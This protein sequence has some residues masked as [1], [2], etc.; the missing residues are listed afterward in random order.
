MSPTVQVDIVLVQ[1]LLSFWDSQGIDITP[2]W[3]LLGMAPAQPMPPWVNAEKLKLVHQY[4]ASQSSDRLLPAR[5]GRYLAQRDLP[6][7][8]LLK[9]SENLS[10]GLPAALRFMNSSLGSI[11]FVIR[12]AEHKVVVRAEP[13]P[14]MPLLPDQLLQALVALTEVCCGVLGGS[15][16]HDLT[17]CAPLE[18]PLIDDLN[19]FLTPLVM[20]GEH[21]ALDISAAAWQRLNPR[22]Q[23][24]MYVSLLRDFDRHAEKLDEQLRLYSELQRILQGCLLKRRI[25]QEDVAAQL[26]ISVRNLQRRLKALGTTYQALLDESR[27]DI[28]M[29]LIRDESL[30][31]YE[32]AFMVG[33][34]EPSAFYKAFKRW[35]DATP[36]DYRQALS[37]ET[38]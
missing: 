24:V 29:R 27:Q 31:L 6:L 23:P 15:A 22:Q 5:T 1:H 16:G 10:Q 25:S 9:Y 3:S 21:Y 2:V 17:V 28:A 19:D 26:N 38:N 35:T 32:I 13:H 34:A 8:R 14:G 30:P 36:G 37:A 12:A 4:I 20:P 11:H 33:Y 18:S 7:G